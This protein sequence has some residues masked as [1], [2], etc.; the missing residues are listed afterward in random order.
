MFAYWVNSADFRIW[1]WNIA[2][3]WRD[4]ADFSLFFWVEEAKASRIWRKLDRHWSRNAR[5]IGSQPANS[6]SG[7]KCFKSSKCDN[8]FQSTSSAAREGIERFIEGSRH[9]KICSDT[10]C[11]RWSE[12]ARSVEKR[13]KTER[14]SGI[15]T[16]KTSLE[17]SLVIV[18]D[19]NIIKLHFIYQS[20]QLS[21]RA[22]QKS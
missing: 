15:C 13:R 22:H 18:A 21:A 10:H 7:S 9:D 6:S 5:R 4:A 12:R 14:S 20:L 19:M 16:I 3:L 8:T 2:Q 1:W 11:A 17:S